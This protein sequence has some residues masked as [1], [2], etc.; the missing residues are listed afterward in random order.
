MLLQRTAAC[1]HWLS[2]VLVE[3]RCADTTKFKT[4]ILAFINALLHGF[5]NL[6]ERCRVREQLLAGQLCRLYSLHVPS[7][8]K[9]DQILDRETKNLVSRLTRA[10]ES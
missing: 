10:V 7:D 1:S 9:R 4:S 3:M 8:A 6:V 2:L 5:D